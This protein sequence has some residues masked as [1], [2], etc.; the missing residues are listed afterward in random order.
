MQERPHEIRLILRKN[1]SDRG[2]ASIME[3]H[4]KRATKQALSKAFSRK[5]MKNPGRKTKQYAHQSKHTA[6]TRFAVSGGQDYSLKW[7][8]VVVK[9][10][11]VTGGGGKA[12]AHLNYI[13]REGVAS[14]GGHGTLF[15]TEGVSDQ[16]FLQNLEAF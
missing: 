1:N 8:R 3:E 16:Q 12:R 5:M 10:R 2:G 6:R 9:T 11:L 7:Q 15:G 4:A 13:T 14:D